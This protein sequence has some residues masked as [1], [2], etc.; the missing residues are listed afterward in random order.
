MLLLGA[1]HPLVAEIEA[2]IS[3]IDALEPAVCASPEQLAVRASPGPR[4]KRTRL[5]L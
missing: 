4:G 1:T 2:E 3:E 5:E